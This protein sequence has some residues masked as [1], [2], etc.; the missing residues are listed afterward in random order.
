M[1]RLI[2]HIK[3]EFFSFYTVLSQVL[4]TK[5]VMHTHTCMFMGM[6]VCMY[7]HLSEGDFKILSYKC[8]E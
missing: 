2:S 4:L 3:L 5:D 8:Q 6:Y 1:K 7:V